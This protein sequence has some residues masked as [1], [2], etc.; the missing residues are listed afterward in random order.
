MNH[1]IFRCK[2]STLFIPYF[3]AH[4]YAFCP[5][6]ANPH[7]LFFCIYK[8]KIVTMY[9]K[10]IYALREKKTIWKLPILPSVVTV[11]WPLSA[12]RSDLTGLS[13]LRIHPRWRCHEISMSAVAG[14]SISST[15]S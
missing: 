7:F 5:S 9:M 2:S 12:L 13:S 10:C 4:F 11:Q 8:T 1:L 15:N 6:H 3:M 14:Y